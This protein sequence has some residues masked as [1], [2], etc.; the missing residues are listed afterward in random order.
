MLLKFFVI[1]FKIEGTTDFGLWYRKGSSFDLITYCDVDYTGDRIERKSTS[2]ACQFLENALISWSCRK[3]NT[4]AL[5]TTE[6]EY[7]S[8]TECCSKVL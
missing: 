7:I 8:T 5:S 3:Q 2:G 4:I 6:A 1:L